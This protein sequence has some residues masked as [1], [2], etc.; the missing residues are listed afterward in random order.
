VAPAPLLILSDARWKGIH[1][2]GRFASEVLRRLPKHTQLANGPKPLSIADPLWLT[3]QVMARRPSVFFSPGFNPP[4]LCFFPFVFTIHDLIQLQVPDVATPHKRFYYQLIVKP[5]S[6]R[7]F[8]VLTVSEY[9]RVQ[10][11]EWSGLPEERVVNV[12]NGVDL[13]F[14][15]E[16]QRYQPGF[17]Y[18]LYVGNFR[19]HKNLHRLML[20]FRRLDYPGLCLL[21]V[22]T[23]N[24]QM[25]ACIRELGLQHRAAFLNTPS[26]HDL[27]C[28]Y[29]GATLLVLPSLI[30]GFGLPA[31]E[32]M[33]CGTPVV[34]SR[35]TALPEVVGEAGLFVDPL[36]VQ[37]MKQAIARVLGDRE[38]RGTLAKLGLQ[39]AQRFSWDGVAAKVR[40]VL[41]EA[42]GGSK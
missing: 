6:H 20:A 39:R 5:A 31:L 10:I 35:N 4:P 30:E 2:I 18:V 28:V 1:G 41:E 26:D 16:G 25:T 33:A 3:S 8:R 37:D 17:P 21:L 36:D 19:P 9:S 7:A 40:A 22:G 38:L 34:V 42:V 12:G 29:R 15:P 11:L 27:A 24:S 13:P 23:P 14:V 32:A